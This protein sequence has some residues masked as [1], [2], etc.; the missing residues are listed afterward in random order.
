[1]NTYR[2][3]PTCLTALLIASA[4]HG[5][6]AQQATEAI[7]ANS[8]VS[9]FP[10][11]S[12]QSVESANTALVDAKKERAEIEARFAQEKQDCLPK[13][14]ISSCVDKAKERRRQALLRLRPVE[15]EANTFKRQSRVTSRDEALEKRRQKDADAGIDRA[16]PSTTPPPFGVEATPPVDGD[17]R[18]GSKPPKKAGVDRTARHEERLKSTPEEERLDAAQRAKN[19]ADYER[20]VKEAEARQQEVAKR[21]AEKYRKIEE[22]RK[23]KDAT[24]Q[25]SGSSSTSTTS[26]TSNDAAAS[27]TTSSTNPSPASGKPQ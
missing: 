18:A 4:A 17:S 15:I 25:S 7:D 3:T 6:Q 1:M 22:K 23:L 21:K 12:I 8:V 24:M 13:F 11:G 2:F 16:A 27:S 9:R 14:F 26:P 20:K 10:P 19:V 5:V